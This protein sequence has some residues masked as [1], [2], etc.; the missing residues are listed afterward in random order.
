MSSNLL[1]NSEDSR[2]H[3]ASDTCGRCRRKFERGHRVTTA[4]IFERAGV[5]P[6]DM[7]SLGAYLEAEF[8]LVHIDCTDPLLVKGVK[9]LT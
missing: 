5:N 4:Y 2:P 9:G 1:L 8:E 6:N 3:V 7:L